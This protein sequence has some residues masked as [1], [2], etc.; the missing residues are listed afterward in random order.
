VIDSL[1][2][3]SKLWLIIIS[4]NASNKKKEYFPSNADFFSRIVSFDTGI[5][6]SLTDR[7][8]YSDLSKLDSTRNLEEMT[9]IQQY[10]EHKRLDVEWSKVIEGYETLSHYDRIR[11]IVERLAK[12]NYSS[13]LGIIERR[14]GIPS[15]SNIIDYY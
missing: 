4:P 14:M 13:H 15:I 10:Q 12:L 8:L 1:Y 7:R 6:E 3:N 5:E 9:W 11:E 2:K